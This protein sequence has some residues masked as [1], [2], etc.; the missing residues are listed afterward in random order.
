MRLK[1]VQIEAKKEIVVA[2]NVNSM[3]EE[4]ETKAELTMNG[5]IYPLLP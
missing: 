3:K 5:N 1:A 2:D 4:F